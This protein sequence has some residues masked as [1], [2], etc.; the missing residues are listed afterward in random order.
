MW[1]T[2]KDLHTDVKAQVIY[3]GSVSR[4][5]K[6]SQGT[7]QGRIPIPSMYKVCINALLNTLTNH[8]HAI[9]IN[10]VHVPSPSFADDIS[11]LTTQQSF[12]AVLMHICY[13][14]RI[15]WRYEVNNSKSGVVTF[16]QRKRVNG[17]WVGILWTSSMNTKIL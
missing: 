5:F 11:L 10:G 15:K 17:F 1:L 8:A 2:I 9:S 6:L 16:G 13:C 14:C 4:Q 12:L 7:S 3:P